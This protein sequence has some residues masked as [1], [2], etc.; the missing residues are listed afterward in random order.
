MKVNFSS[1]QVKV[2]LI[3]A[4]AMGITLAVSVGAL[5][6]VYAAIKDL[7]RI[8]RDDFT[9][10][11]TIA[12]SMSDFKEQVQEWKNVLLRGRDAE[13]LKKRWA[14][15]EKAE[16]DTVE[17][18]KE[19]RSGTPHDKVRTKIEEALVA[20]KVAGEVYRKAFETY[21]SASLDPYAG[22]AVAR[23]A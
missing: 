15:F 20:H 5:T 19:A 22:D 2:L 16:K 13:E 14:A 1:L 9:T 6:Q 18:L 10:Q 21:K 11:Q 12:L 17:R 4:V 23:G 3:A 7:D 8:S